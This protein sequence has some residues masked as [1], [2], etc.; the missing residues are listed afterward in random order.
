MQNN[1]PTVHISEIHCSIV[2]SNNIS[3][4]FG[5]LYKCKI[6]VLPWQHWR[7]REP[8]F[9]VDQLLIL[10]SMFEKY[11]RE[12]P[13]IVNAHTDR[14]LVFYLLLKR[15]SKTFSFSYT[16][17]LLRIRFFLFGVRVSRSQVRIFSKLLHVISVAFK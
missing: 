17:S 10:K 16:E 3:T 1:I 13:A 9:S 14:P 4:I 5:V 2:K 15:L 11:R 6:I 8:A 7:K 12:V